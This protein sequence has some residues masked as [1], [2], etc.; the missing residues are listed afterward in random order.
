M[1]RAQRRAAAREHRRHQHQWVTK[2][3]QVK[4]GDWHGFTV[5]VDC[6]AHQEDQ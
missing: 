6:G 4:G 1:N 3:T 2:H 5:C